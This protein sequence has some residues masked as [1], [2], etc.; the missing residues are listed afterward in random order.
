MRRKKLDKGV[1]TT[2]NREKCERLKSIGFKWATPKGQAAWNKRFEE[3]KE[4]KQ[5]V[6]IAYEEYNFYL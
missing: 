3:L 5:K 2:M 6:S 4:Y 1:D